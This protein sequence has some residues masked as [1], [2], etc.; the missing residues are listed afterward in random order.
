MGFSRVHLRIAASLALFL[1]GGAAGALL[2]RTPQA[3]SPSPR[4]TAAS[5][6]APRT[7][8]R[9]GLADVPRRR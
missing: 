8:S 1:T 2:W 9:P 6:K 4:W 3:T 7:A 5:A